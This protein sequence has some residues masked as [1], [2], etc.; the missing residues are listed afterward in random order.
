MKHGAGGKWY[1]NARNYS[2]ELADERNM[3]A[4]LTEQWMNF[5]TV[6]IRKIMGFSS[7]GLGYKLKMPIIGRV[8]RW[9]AE[10]MIHS[11]SPGRKPVRADGHFGQVI[12]VEEAKII[13][14]SLAAEPIIQNYCMC[15]M[16][17]RNVKDVCCINFGVLSGVIEKLP[18]FI[19]SNTKVRLGR[20]EAVAAVEEQNRKGRVA[21]V[22]FQ[23]VPYVCAICSCEVP[24]CGGLRL[25]TDF[26]LHAVYKAEYV[27]DTNPDL[28]QGC[29]AC[30]AQ[31]QFGAIRYSPTL[32]R[33]LVDQARCFGCG[34]C[35]DACRF[36]ALKL[37]PREEVPGLVGQ[38]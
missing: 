36:G 31:C 6:F 34:L 32:K 27:A 25:R 4:Y 14:S 8:L 1:L 22:W 35:R 3:E 11:E 29:K 19:P 12:P 38:Y 23:P 26:G 9:Q 21:T 13:L 18:R 7:I 30:V 17:Q 2:N 5:E 15:R 16:M 10:S 37:I 33:V 20:E 28:C 24:Q